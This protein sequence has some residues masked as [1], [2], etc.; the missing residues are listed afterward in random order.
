ML[1]V[2]VNCV[3]Y[4]MCNTETAHTSAQRSSS[5]SSQATATLRWQRSPLGVQADHL[6]FHTPCPTEQL[7]QLLISPCTSEPVRSQQHLLDAR[8]TRTCTHTPTPAPVKL[9]ISQHIAQPK[10]KHMPL[11][12][13]P[14]CIN[15]PYQLPSHAPVAGVVT[16]NTYRPTFW[17][18]SHV[19]VH[20]HTHMHSFCTN[21]HQPTTSYAQ[22]PRP[23]PRPLGHG[24]G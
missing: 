13:T 1:E 2:V 5:C 22:Q 24:V 16:H 23:Q 19:H 11:G 20:M 17:H 14:W 4:S 15:H 18:T 10:P 3:K 7:Q 9:P 12:K 8:R 21:Q 6:P